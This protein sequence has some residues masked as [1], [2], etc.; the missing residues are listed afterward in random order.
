MS[1]ERGDCRSASSY[2][3]A[4]KK[5]ELE[6]DHCNS[7]FK[8]HSA[9]LN[10]SFLKVAYAKNRPDRARLTHFVK[11]DLPAMAE[12][13]R[14]WDALS[15]LIADR[16]VAAGDTLPDNAGPREFGEA[17]TLAIGG[18]S[19]V[20]RAKAPYCASTPPPDDPDDDFDVI[21]VL[22]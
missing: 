12:G 2:K 17:L 3:M 20:A 15:D 14:G 19:E 21:E 7:I 22:R 5:F 16:L 13:M 4:I 8:K 18:A 11:A 6:K 9:S 10:S 1:E